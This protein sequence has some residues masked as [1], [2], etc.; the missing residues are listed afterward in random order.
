MPKINITLKETWGARI[1]TELY[2]DEKSIGFIYTGEN[3]E[4]EV[5]AGQHILQAKIA[6]HSGKTLNFTTFNKE[7][8]SLTVFTNK[9]AD[10]F[11]PIALLNFCLLAFLVFGNL[12]SKPYYFIYS[13]IFFFVL[14]LSYYFLIVRRNRYFIIK[15]R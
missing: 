10:I 3:K 15:E 2:L 8:K 12:K 5:P 1:R 7:I 4:I 11:L 13:M 6:R 9:I 14:I